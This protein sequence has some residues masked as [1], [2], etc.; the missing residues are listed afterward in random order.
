MD[1]KSIVDRERKYRE[2]LKRIPGGEPTRTDQDRADLLALVTELLD[3]LAENGHVPDGEDRCTDCC[4]GC[5]A[6]ELLTE[7]GEA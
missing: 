5:E 4:P 2:T 3:R 1:L 7:I 6:E